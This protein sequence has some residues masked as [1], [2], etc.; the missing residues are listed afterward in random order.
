[1]LKK[2]KT[3]LLWEKPLHYFCFIVFD[4]YI[5][6]TKY[7]HPL[8][9]HD[10]I[11]FSTIKSLSLIFEFVH[12][13][14]PGW[15]LVGGARPII[16]CT[17]QMLMVMIMRKTE[18]PKAVRWQRV[19][20]FLTRV[21]FYQEEGNRV[22]PKIVVLILFGIYDC[23]SGGRQQSGSHSKRWWRSGSTWVFCVTAG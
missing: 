21:N 19:P 6:P 17:S 22:D 20:W 2:K 8:Y 23:C 16:R 10:Q 1:M 3:N 11:V 13:S 7:S 12:L 9:D 15:G 14:R 18:V 5:P 4:N